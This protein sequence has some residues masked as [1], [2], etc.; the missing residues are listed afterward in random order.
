MGELITV[1]DKQQ[2]C[3]TWKQRRQRRRLNMA[4]PYRPDCDIITSFAHVDEIV[5]QNDPH[6]TWDCTNGKSLDLLLYLQLLIVTTLHSWTTLH[7]NNTRH[8]L[9]CN[10]NGNL[11]ASLMKLQCFEMQSQGRVKFCFNYL[12]KFS[13]WGTW[14]NLKLTLEQISV[15]QQCCVILV[16]L[17]HHVVRH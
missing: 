14:P 4:E 2:S 8:G 1:V 5:H 3:Q 6:G 12:P 13:F 10:N 11:K 15:E 17:C 16:K 9:D 7:S